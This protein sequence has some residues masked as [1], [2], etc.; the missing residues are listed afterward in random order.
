MIVRISFDAKSAARR[1][2][3]SNLYVLAEPRFSQVSPL[4]SQFVTVL[5][6]ANSIVITAFAVAGA[7]YTN[8]FFAPAVIVSLPFL[9]ATVTLLTVISAALQA[10]RSIIKLISP[11]AAK[12]VVEKSDNSSANN[13]IAASNLFFLM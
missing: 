9:S 5:D 13:R 10:D 7:A 6:A 8:W 11:S 3:P 1:Y 4:I 2:L 12:I